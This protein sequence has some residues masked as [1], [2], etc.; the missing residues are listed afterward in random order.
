MNFYLPVLLLA[1]A[2]S[3][4][5]HSSAIELNAGFLDSQSSAARALTDLA[6]T[7]SVDKQLYLLQ[8]D[9]PMRDSWMQQ[10]LATGVQVL[11]AIPQN[12]YLVYGDGKALN[13]VAALE[14]TLPLRWYGVF[15][16]AAKWQ[17][18]AHPVDA[19]PVVGQFEVQLVKDS[20]ANSQT[21]ALLTQFNASSSLN[22][23]SP[24]IHQ[25]FEIL[26]FVNLV[27]S[28]PQARLAQLLARPDVISVRRASLIRFQDESQSMIIAGDLIGGTEPNT[29][30]Y[31]D[32][33]ASWGFTQAQFDQSNL[34]VDVADNSV[35]INP[36][37]P[38][39][40]TVPFLSNAG[41]I[42]RPRHFSLYTGG[43]PSNT[44]RYVY[45]GNWSS[46]PNIGFGYNGHG[47]M[48]MSVLG[49]FVPNSLDSGNSL[50]HRDAKGFRY[51]MG[52]APFVRLGNS[53]V[54]GGFGTQGIPIVPAAYSSGA[55]ISTNSWIGGGS[56][57][58]G[59]LSQAYD[60]FTRDAQP[61]QAG[62][63]PMFFA[64]AAGNYGSSEESRTMGEPATAKNVLSVGAS[65]GVRSKAGV[66]GGMPTSTD[67]LGDCGVRDTD[68]DNAKDMAFFSSRG[69]SSDGRAKPDVVAPG[70]HITG[71]S[72]TA[73]G[74][75]PFLPL[76]NLGAGDPLFD[77]S[78]HCGLIGSGIT[79]GSPNNFFPFSTGQRWYT[80]TSGTSFAT[81]AAAGSAALIYQ[82][83]LN[84]PNYLAA[85]RTPVGSAA[86]SP[87][88]TKAYLMNTTR[89]LSG[90]RAN[91]R[92][93]SMGQGMGA[94]NL[95]HAF[96]GVQ[97]VIRDQV[98]AD[99][100]SDSGQTRTLLVAVSDA[101]KP[102]RVSMVYTDAPGSTV[103][104]ASVNDLDLIVTG[105]G[106]KYLGNVFSKEH[107]TTGGMA[108]QRNNA[109]H[110]FLPAGIRAG[111]VFVIRINATAINGDGL[112]GNGD[113]TD[114]DYALVVYNADVVTDQAVVAFENAEINTPSQRLQP[115]DCTSLLVR[116]KNEGTQAALNLTASL[117]SASAGVSVSQNSNSFPLI[118]TGAI[119]SGTNA[120]T[121]STSGSLQCGST[122]NLSHQVNMG[123]FSFNT[124][125]QLHVGT[126]SG[127]RF[128][129][130][131][132]QI[133]AGGELV[134]S[135][136]TQ[137]RVFSVPVPFAIRVYDKSIA[138]GESIFVSTN[139][140]VQL[141][142][143]QASSWHLN[144]ALPA[145]QFSATTIAP[146]W[147]EL[148]LDTRSVS[149][150]GIYQ[151][152]TG[153]SPNRTWIIEWRAKRAE[154]TGSA[155]RLK[156]AVAFQE[157]SDTIEFIYDAIGQNQA[158]GASASIGL[159][160]TDLRHT[161]FSINAPSVTAGQ[162][163]RFER[164]ASACSSGRGSCAVQA[165]G[166]FANGFE[167]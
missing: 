127:Y 12:A 44:S 51:G 162:K 111:E 61:N 19:E 141:N 107:S 66:S 113:V 109:E 123:G 48:V 24:T 73:A 30:N 140:V 52:V 9:Q 101:S 156:F 56:G 60:A 137:D 46:D 92:L 75:N 142:D 40:G 85:H 100:L 17:Q 108:D 93:P 3:T 23:A 16:M 70:T 133:P 32:K 77:A 71:M 150:G 57:E 79:P 13:K 124:P 45:K 35:D 1:I 62:L 58:Y 120:Y 41:P 55:R 119:S 149:G 38:D 34:I 125:M 5:A 158:G 53:V 163:I 102:F 74:V 86:P 129:T 147:D 151:K 132:G 83:F 50:I 128:S 135:T 59:L 10:L 80:I 95:G 68:A 94:I 7:P 134:P 82:Q 152:V 130:A 78:G 121:L 42:A 33:L 43:D 37:G 21:I 146:Y 161:T 15:P 105:A 104:S 122:V 64:F 20:I 103:G 155:I 31:L 22:A 84:N 153:T 89:Y 18:N 96:D 148:K 87:A 4:G 76:N 11:N 91:D 106:A 143:G 88:L 47:Q 39:P 14:N 115:N 98:G 157:N 117:Q 164:V 97:R 63:Q 81:P 154:D 29:G 65:E 136:A 99:T 118:N 114:Q 112:P 26:Q 110:V 49:G 166:Y 54:F 145:S 28:F 131:S 6:K 67:G 69:P 116:L 159:Q 144:E 72:F 2:C 25:R 8:F 165:S 90:E 139:G 160:T 36:I 126:P 27:T 138:S 167:D